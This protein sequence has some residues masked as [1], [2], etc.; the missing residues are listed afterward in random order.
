MHLHDIPFKIFLRNKSQCC[1]F[2]AWDATNLKK[3]SPLMNG[4]RFSTF[5]AQRQRRTRE[6][7]WQDAVE[8]H[9]L[10][11]A[12]RN[13]LGDHQRHSPNLKKCHGTPVTQYC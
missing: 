1:A 4:S 7:H 3:Y 5:R 2:L 11:D 6:L 10:D 12:Y 9:Y 8:E 13:E